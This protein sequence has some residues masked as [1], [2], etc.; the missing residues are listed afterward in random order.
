MTPYLIEAPWLKTRPPGISDAMHHYYMAESYLASVSRN[1]A[2]NELEQA[3]K[4]EPNNPKFHLLQAKILLDQDKSS[5]AAK[6]VFAALERDKDGISQVLAM[7]DEFYLPDAK[8]VY[9]KVISMGSKEVLPYLGLGNIALHSGDLAEAEKWFVQA[10]QLQPEHPAVLLAW[11]RL[12]AVKA[13]RQTDQSQAKAL[14]QEARALLEKSNAR[15]EESATI[16]SELGDVYFRLAM[17]DK[18]AVSYTEALR[19][20]RRR[21][22]WRLNVA[23]AY[24]RLG[25]VAESERKYREVLALSPDD[26]EAWKGLRDLGKRY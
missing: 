21:N 17:W 8:A 14:L 10:R 5:E 4:L 19:M 16:H 9:A 11:G 2:L 15:G 12:T 23:T 6:A 3:I 25:K 26:A 13:K 22:D 24:A 1:R 20:R 7:S 18:A